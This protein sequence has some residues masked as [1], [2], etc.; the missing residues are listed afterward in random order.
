MPR[1]FGTSGI[2]GLVG[3]DITP[4]LCFG[5]GKALGSS[6]TEGARV[7]VASDTR[8]SSG[9]LKEAF[10]SGLVSSGTR[11]ADWGVLPTPAL[12]LITQELGFA[13]G[14]M[15][16]ASHNP[17]QY[18]G[19]KLFHSSGLAYGRRQEEELEAIYREG[20]FSNSSRGTLDHDLQG[21][22]TYYHLLCR[23]LPPLSPSWRVVVDPGNGAMAGFV[24]RLFEELGLEVS[25]VN[26]EPDG[27]FPGRGPEPTELSLQGTVEFLREKG[28]DIAV[29]FDGDGDRVAFC[30]SRGFL[31]FN[32]MLAF[33]SHLML[34][35]SPGGKV[36]A[37][38]ETGRLLE[39]ALRGRG[40][41]VRGEVG[42]GPVAH[43]CRQLRAALGVEPV[44]VYILPSMGY[45]PD[46][47]FASLLL[48][49]RLRQIGDIREFLGTLPRLFL[50][51]AK[52]PCPREKMERVGQPLRTEGPLFGATEVNNLDGLRLE[53][54][55][56]WMLLRPSGTEPVIRVI[57]EATS[58]ERAR[59]LVGM[60]QQYVESLLNGGAAR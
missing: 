11:V 4:E 40:E 59:A 30:D 5:V 58:P 20:R 35:D 44:G 47:I 51:K 37:T 56:A 54:D 49:S 50:E 38:V 7:A 29:C 28:G 53:F 34:R 24:T 18:N 57:A 60:G 22:G 42:D 17:P 39:F 6:L 8:Q 27:L 16:T 9:A 52:V 32:E 48:L 55:D 13:A 25:A 15:I 14:A 19:L 3:E 46:G 45:Y 1:L 23:R 26:D 2:R 41:V 36:A 33:L 21:L 12:A 10:V 43:L 31:G